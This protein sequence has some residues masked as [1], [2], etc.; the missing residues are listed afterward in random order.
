MGSKVIKPLINVKIFPLPSNIFFNSKKILLLTHYYVVFLCVPN[1][2]SLRMLLACLSMF[3]T[4]LMRPG[5][6]RSLYHLPLQ[7][8]TNS[9]A[10]FISICIDELPFTNKCYEMKDNMAFLSYNEKICEV[11]QNTSFHVEIS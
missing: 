7:Q 6:Q 9:Y 5:L 11:S 1:S 2:H 4:S 8:F 10:I 3:Y